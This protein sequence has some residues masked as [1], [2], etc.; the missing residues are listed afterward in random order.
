MPTSN[1]SSTYEYTIKETRIQTEMML[2]SSTQSAT[3][4]ETPSERSQPNDVTRINDVLGDASTLN[5]TKPSTELDSKSPRCAINLY[6]LPRSFSD[7]V[8][9]SLVKNVIRT[10]AKHNCDYFIHYYNVTLE[11]SGRSGNGGEIRPDEIHDIR[12]HILDAA[13]NSSSQTPIIIAFRS[14]T[15]DEF[16][17]HRNETVQKVRHTKD[18]NGN[19]YYFPWK[20]ANY[21]YPQTT[22]NVSFGKKYISIPNIHSHGLHICSTTYL[23]H[24]ITADYQNVA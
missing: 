6:G 2:E 17:S 13:I 16:W 19:Y 7:H 4:E 15:N 5:A 9:P 8:L 1:T 10:N 21:R 22:D 12:S 23:A 11:E 18:I 14:H 20:E 3:N 24:S